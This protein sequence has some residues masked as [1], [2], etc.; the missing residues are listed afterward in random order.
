M[1]SLREL[2]VERLWT[3]R[4]L[5]ERAAVSPRTI[6]QLE[7]GRLLPRFGTMRRLAAALDVEPAVVDEFAAA[8]SQRAAP[9]SA[10]VEPRAGAAPTAESQH[11][12]QRPMEAHD[13]DEAWEW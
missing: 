2:R 12:T 5:A 9:H 13:G 10:K 4:Q 11:A 6:V 1:P 8:I 3:I 7:H